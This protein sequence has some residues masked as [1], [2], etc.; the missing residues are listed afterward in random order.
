MEH[1][2]LTGCTLSVDTTNQYRPQLNCDGVAH[3]FCCEAHKATFLRMYWRIKDEAA[4]LVQA[5]PY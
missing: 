1:C 2:H 4:L 5:S 3:Q